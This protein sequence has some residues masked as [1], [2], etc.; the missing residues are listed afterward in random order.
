MT[1]TVP[2]MMSEVNGSSSIMKQNRAAIA[3]PMPMRL[4]TANRNPVAS[5][6]HF[7]ANGVVD[8][9]MITP[10]YAIA[11]CILDISRAYIQVKKKA[12]GFARGLFREFVV[13]CYINNPLRHTGGN[14]HTTA[15]L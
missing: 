8:Q 14:V 1:M 12:T 5:V 15:L 10:M 7:K 11:M 13:T 6:L 3:V 2:M 4:V 9:I